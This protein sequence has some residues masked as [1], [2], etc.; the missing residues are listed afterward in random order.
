MERP[1]GSLRLASW[2]NG[3]LGIIG[4]TE[5]IAAMDS[6]ILVPEG[7]AM[8]EWCRRLTEENGSEWR[9]ARVNQTDFDSKGPQTLDDVLKDPPSLGI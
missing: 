9:Y 6:H 1:A 5:N 3:Y 7:L 4:N 8:S 2:S